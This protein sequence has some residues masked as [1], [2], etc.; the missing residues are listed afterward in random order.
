MASLL[1][2][3][4]PLANHTLVMWDGRPQVMQHFLY[5]FTLTSPSQKHHSSATIPLLC[6]LLSAQ[7]QGFLLHSKIKA[8]IYVKDRKSRKSYLCSGAEFLNQSLQLKGEK[9]KEDGEYLAIRPYPSACEMKKCTLLHFLL[10]ECL[11]WSQRTRWPSGSSD[12]LSSTPGQQE[13]S[14][15]VLVWSLQTAPSHVTEGI[16]QTL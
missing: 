3:V 11:C 9:G 14:C 5:G 15:S 6:Q 4:P 13:W 2:S 10:A 1:S 8:E 12:G 7:L 16:H